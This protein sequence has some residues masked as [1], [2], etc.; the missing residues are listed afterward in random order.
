MVIDKPFTS[1]I[2]AAL[3]LVE[4]MLPGMGVMLRVKGNGVEDANYSSIGAM[5]SATAETPAIAILTALF[6][7]LATKERE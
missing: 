1:S 4:R 5:T 2:D 6:T 7:A 3:A